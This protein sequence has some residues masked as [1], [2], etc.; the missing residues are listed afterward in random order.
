[1]SYARLPKFDSHIAGL[2]KLHTKSL[3]THSKQKPNSMM[4]TIK[5]SNINSIYIDPQLALN[6]LLTDFRNRSHNVMLINIDT[7]PVTT[8][9]SGHF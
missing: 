2:H 5:D 8:K 9:I 4:I 3:K 1:M 6:S 7:D